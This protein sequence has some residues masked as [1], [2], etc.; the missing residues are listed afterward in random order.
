MW[1]CLRGKKRVEN[2]ICPLSTGWRLYYCSLVVT[3]CSSVW[4]TL[5]LVHVHGIN[6]ALGCPLQ[7]CWPVPSYCIQCNLTHYVIEDCPVL[8]P[9]DQERGESWEVTGVVCRQHKLCILGTW[10]THEHNKSVEIDFIMLRIVWQGALELTTPINT[11]HTVFSARAQ[12]SYVGKGHQWRI[13]TTAGFVSMQ[14]D[15]GADATCGVY[16]CV[17][18]S[19]NCIPEQL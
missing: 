10:V 11:T 19:S 4:I 6:I 13:L 3:V 14:I 12:P 16:V 17:L 8:R 9:R 7:Y 5:Y 2:S 18:E 1:V 15:L